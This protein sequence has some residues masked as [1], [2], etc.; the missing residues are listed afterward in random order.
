ML[1][2]VRSIPEPKIQEAPKVRWE[3]WLRFDSSRG[4]IVEGVNPYDAQR[5]AAILLGVPQYLIEVRRAVTLEHRL[6][7]KVLA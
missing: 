7:G 1:S 6:P 5:T 2:L 4:T 3:A